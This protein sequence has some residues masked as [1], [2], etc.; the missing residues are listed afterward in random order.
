MTKGLHRAVAI[1]RAK[2]ARLVAALLSL[3]V[4]SFFVYRGSAAIFAD[5]T[6]N[7]TNNWAAGS[8][9]LTNDPDGSGF[10]DATTA[11]FNESGLIPGDTSSG[12]IDVRY[13]GTVTAAASLTDVFLYTANLAD[14]DGGSDS[15]DGAKLSDDIDI[16]VNIYA[17][18]ETCA[19]ASPTK[20]LI[21]A[22]D[23]LDNMP[24]TFG[25]GINSGWKPSATG[26]IRAFEFVWTLGADTASDAQGDS[27]QVDFVWEIQTI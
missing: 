17:A 27:T 11:E 4:V 26:E 3:V 25:I 5:T 8:L 19:T 14:S 24:T 16:V 2:R 22:S 12:C 18:S 10:G 13:D 9:A 1:E 21:F 20:T 15:G 23:A 6:D 7:V